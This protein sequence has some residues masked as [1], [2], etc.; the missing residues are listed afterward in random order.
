M[1]L[2]LLGNI[3]D[4]VL[5]PVLDDWAGLFGPG[6]LRQRLQ[7]LIPEEDEL[8]GALNALLADGS[9][10]AGHVKPYHQASP[11]SPGLISQWLSRV[12]HRR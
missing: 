6:G 7:E 3:E 8:H 4:G 1:V 12:R 5:A 11:F 2:T 10:I 9:T